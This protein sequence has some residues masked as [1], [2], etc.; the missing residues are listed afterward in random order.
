MTQTVA[1]RGKTV[2]VDG[3]KLIELRTRKN[4]TQEKLADRAILSVRTVQNIERGRPTQRSTL[5]KVA[6]ALGVSAGDLI[7][8]GSSSAACQSTESAGGVLRSIPNSPYRGL[9]AFT[10]KDNKLFF[11]RDRVVGLLVRKLAQNKLV[12]ISGPS[13][14]GKS[15]LVAAGLIPELR[16]SGSW[17][18]VSFRPGPD[19]FVALAGALIPLLEPAADHIAQ[20]VQ[21]PTLVRDLRDGQLPSL[22]QKIPHNVGTPLLFIDQFEELF[23]FDNQHEVRSRFLDSL[24]GAALGELSSNGR[25]RIVCAVRS[26]WA[27]RV[28]SHRGF[29]DLIQD[30]DVKLGPLTDEEVRQATEQ[31]AALSGMRFEPG[32]VQRLVADAGAE[33]GTLPLLQFALAQLWDRQTAGVLTHAAYDEIGQL[34]GAIANRAEAVFR[35]LTSSQQEIARGILTSLVHVADGGDGHTRRRLAISALYAD[36]RLNT[37]EGRHVVHLLIE[38]RLLTTGLQEVVR[39]E[40]IELAHEAVIRRWPRFRQW[41]QEDGEL[42]AWRDRLRIILEEWQKSGRDDAFLLRG[43]LLDEA[44]LWLAKCGRLLGGPERQLIH[45]SYARRQQDRWSRPLRSLDVL[46]DASAREIHSTTGPFSARAGASRLWR[47]QVQLFAVSPAQERELTSRLPQVPAT[48]ALTLLDAKPPARLEIDEAGEWVEDAVGTRCIDADALRFLENLQRRGGTGPALEFLAPQLDSIHD[49]TLRL[50]LASILFDM[51][52]LRGRYEDAATL[53]EQELA[54]HARA[55][56]PLVPLLLSLRI[57]LLHHQMFYRP[58][59]DLWSA[60]LD[61]L[62]QCDPASASYGEILFMLGGNLG[63]LRGD[64]R[65]ARRFL[66]RALRHALR[67]GDDYLLSRCLRKYGDYLRFCGH[68][69]LAL[70]VLRESRRLAQRGRGTR[71]RI[72]VTACLGDLERQ[73]GN[74]QAARELFEQTLAWAKEAYIPGWVAHAYLGMA[75]LAFA[76]NRTEEAEIFAEQA[77]S[78]YRNTRPGH[79]WGE[80]QIALLRGRLLRATGQQQWRDVLEQVHRRASAVGYQHDAAMAR[81]ALEH[82]RSFANVLMFL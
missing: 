32:L 31:P 51:M 10:E 54:F 14:S 25:L 20:A 46:V 52:H 68:L 69:Q 8:T 44:S 62:A 78:Q 48:H 5:V 42:L 45:A 57:R 43:P 15:S 58:V 73:R 47:L 17:A 9:L 21:V 18:I 66:V 11:G 75:E 27:H 19:P 35:S 60:M 49:T 71:Q 41:L 74:F 59:D 37:D 67:L 2:Q 40:T 23:A 12:Q 16:R 29:T 36:D 82:Y 26:D 64:Y 33:P 79:L 28:L 76:A 53:I 24:V 30:G 63:V 4:W 56:L 72:Y 22:L 61:L 81:H 6:D 39:Q 38:A 34:S 1:S 7:L 80:I 50:K 65:E 55:D 70:A 13:G 3:Y 77:D